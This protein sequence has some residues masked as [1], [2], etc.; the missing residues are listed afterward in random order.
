VVLEPEDARDVVRAE[1]ATDS[2]A[3]PATAKAA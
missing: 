1:L 2:A 3:Q